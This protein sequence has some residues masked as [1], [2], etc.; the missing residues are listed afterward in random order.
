MI[1]SVAW[2]HL[3][4]KMANIQTCLIYFN[5]LQGITVPYTHMKDGWKKRN[6]KKTVHLVG[7]V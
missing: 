2:L 5:I 3:D 7:F 4:P 1:F 6:Y